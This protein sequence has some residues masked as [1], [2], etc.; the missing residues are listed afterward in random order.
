MRDA[1]AAEIEAAIG[2]TRAELGRTLDA[3][4]HKLAA[5]RLLQ[6]GIAMITES[7][8]AE[9]GGRSALAEIARANPIPLALIGAGIGWLIANNTGMLDRIAHDERVRRAVRQITDL[10]GTTGEGWEGGTAGGWVHRAAGAAKGA[11]GAVRDTGSAVVERSA[12]Y[13]ELAGERTAR[14]RD[15]GQAAVE[16]AGEQASATWERHALLFGLVGLVSAAV[17]AAMLPLTRI[18]TK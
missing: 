4:E 12:A 15:T 7:F 5:P 13:R 2:H 17:V 6:E 3:L 14:W 16:R 10:A 18:E 9:G 11:I 8:G 1:P